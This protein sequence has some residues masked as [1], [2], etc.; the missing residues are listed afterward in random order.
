MNL[1][2][3]IAC[4]DRWK[5]IAALEHAS[6][7]SYLSPVS[8]IPV[9]KK[10]KISAN[11]IGFGPFGFSYVTSKAGYS[12]EPIQIAINLGGPPQLEMLVGGRSDAGTSVPCDIKLTLCFKSQK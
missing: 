1:S 12:P 5:S 9:S 8:K 7:D 10:I 6:K 4:T 3:G 2:S 11:F